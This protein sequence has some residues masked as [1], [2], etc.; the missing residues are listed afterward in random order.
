MMR[1]D[2]VSTD[3]LGI[4][5]QILTVIANEQCDIIAMEVRHNHTYLH[6]NPNAMSFTDIATK[7]AA[8][9]GV[10]EINPVALLPGEKTTQQLQALL[11]NIP[12][13][14]IDVDHRGIIINA[15]RAAIEQAGVDSERFINRAL[16]SF[17]EERLRIYLSGQSTT[18]E[19]TFAGNPFYA[20]ITPVRSEHEVSGAVIVLRSLLNVGRHISQY[21]QGMHRGFDS[22]IGES[23]VIERVK[24]LTR[25]F[26]SIDL[27][28]LITGETGTGKELIARALHDH[29]QRASKPFLAINCAAMPEHLLEAE[30]FGYA[31]GAYTGAKQG[32]KPGLFELADG[33][34][35]LLDE[36]GEMALPLQAK[37]LRF[38]QDFRIRRLG[39]VKDKRV[40]V[41]IVSATHQ[42]LLAMISKGLFRE[43]LYYRLNVLQLD[44]PPLR[45][46][47]NDVLLLIEHFLQHASVHVN[48]SPLRLSEAVLEKMQNYPWPGNVRQLQNV[49]YRLAAQSDSTLIDSD[50]DLL[51]SYSEQVS[52]MAQI[53]SLAGDISQADSWQDAQQAFEKS[54]LSRLY[55]L[56]PSTRKLAQRLGVS[57]NKIAIKLRQYNI[58]C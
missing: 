26:A 18:Q 57:H 35:L 29:G 37:L 32:G 15:N 51:S 53:H 52:K 42:N 24:A 44:M 3:R 30:L 22:I 46:R 49:I 21:Q 11:T 58:Q 43:D 50:Y 20:D 9:D 5:Q 27:P 28:V 38:L 40:D 25:K 36:I 8:I 14:I 31:S 56:Y 55:P 54:L 4:A 1:L 13:P 47:N 7:I 10:H 39:G 23:E 12:E 16:Q 6:I 2:V 45:E 19:V 48:K 17:I 34:T 33:G 41:R